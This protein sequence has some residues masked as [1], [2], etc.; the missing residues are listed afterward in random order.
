MA[1]SFSRELRQYHKVR[2]ELAVAE[3]VLMRGSRVVI[4]TSLRQDMLQHIH[5]GHQGTKC[6]DM[7]RQSVWWPG[8]AAELET[9]AKNCD[10]CSKLQPPATSSLI[11]SSL[12]Q[13][14]W[15]K[16]GTDLFKY[17]WKQYNYTSSSSTTTLDSSKSLF[18]PT[19]RQKQSCDT[20]RVL[21]FFAT[22]KRLLEK[23]KDPYLDLDQP[24]F[25]TVTRHLNS[26]CHV[27]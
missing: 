22:V 4:P 16:V 12:P 7:A 21:F 24:H 13:L 1:R 10:T 15:Q 17:M 8:L 27:S 11:P 2:C 26:S 19:R 9:P 23:E 14:P 5:T 20:L 18:C 25:R 3:G 6:R